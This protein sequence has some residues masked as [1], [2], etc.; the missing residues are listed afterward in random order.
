MLQIIQS[1]LP[2]YWQWLVNNATIEIDENIRLLRLYRLTGNVFYRNKIVLQNQLLIYKEAHKY[3]R[4][5]QDFEELYPE[6]VMGFIEGVE[7]YSLSKAIS[8]GRMMK[9]TSFC[10]MY[11]KKHII[12]YIESKGT[13]I[14]VSWRVHKEAAKIK[15]AINGL[16][17]SECLSE[18]EQMLEGKRHHTRQAILFVLYHS[19][20]I[21]ND[22]TITNYHKKEE[23]K[24]Q[25]NP[26]N[27]IED[28]PL[29]TEDEKIIVLKFYSDNV[30]NK[31]LAKSAK[32][33]ILKVKKWITD[34]NIKQIDYD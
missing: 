6:A 18:I 15:K 9:I 7:K 21:D 25:I 10:V 2:S 1:T 31:Y 30:L 11:M 16:P 8:N 4:N 20:N 23:P 14:N 5:T 27:I 3:S 19:R 33:I 12:G 32:K 17:V 34:K 24:K 22:Y 13:L 26:Y 28:C 29:I